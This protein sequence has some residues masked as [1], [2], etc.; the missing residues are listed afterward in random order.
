MRLFAVRLAPATV[1]FV[2][3]EAFRLASVPFDIT[4]PG[5]EVFP[6]TRLRLLLPNVKFALP[7]IDRF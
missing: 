2:V 6:R 5:L 1:I 4:M 3:A 7:L